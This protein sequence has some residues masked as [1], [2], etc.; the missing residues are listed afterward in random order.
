LRHRAITRLKARI[1]AV[2]RS[3]RRGERAMAAFVAAF[4]ATGFGVLLFGKWRQ[5]LFMDTA[6]AY[7]WGLKFL[8]GYGRHP[9]L[10][11]WIAG[12]WYRV[13][14]AANWA[15]YLLSEIA[16]AVSLGATFLVAR[17]VVGPRRAALATFAMMLYPLFIG[18]K[19]DHFNNYQVLLALLPF[20]VWLFLVAWEKRSIAAG[21]ALG[22]AAAACTMTIYSGALGVVAIA[23]AA[24]VSAERRAFLTSPAPYAAALVYLA[25]LSPH[26]IWLLQGHDASL[27][28]AARYAG[29]AAAA[30]GELYYLGRY[31]GQQFGL[32]AFVFGGLLIALWPWRVRGPVFRSAVVL[33]GE[34]LLVVVIAAVLVVAPLVAAVVMR[35]PLQPDWG[36]SLFSLLPVAAIA[37]LPGLVVS[38]NAVARAAL[39][40]GVWA[41]ALLV[42]Q[43][44]YEAVNFRARPDYRAYEP[45]S[46]LAG[47]VTRRWHDRFGVPLPFLVA[48]LEVAGPLAFYSADHP[49]MMSAD[50]TMFSPWIDD[51]AA[52]KTRGYAGVCRDGDARCAAFLQNLNPAAERFDIVLARRSG[53]V[54]A[55]P[56]TFH[57]QFSP[58]AAAR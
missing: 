24:L 18:A 13:F 8:G 2:L 41:L 25:A 26:L 10:T 48:E 17:R 1:V 37:A 49:L 47:E 38:W 11:G 20:T 30:R 43:P 35:L 39:L 14:P 34:R 44:V 33:R 6:E 5:D 40:A 19:A 22:L 4:A 3:P 27:D 57:V 32:L 56:H 52:L 51:P 16:I 46:E 29:G 23:L 50:E 45:L 55:S 42:G 53:G 28:Y 31:A 12:V 54:A 21:A 15:A 58:P 7:T 36:N 9:P